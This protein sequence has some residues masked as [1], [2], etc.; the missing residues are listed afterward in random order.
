MREHDVGDSMYNLKFINKHW[1][2]IA[3]IML[4]ILITL[5]FSNCFFKKGVRLEFEV[6]SEM[7]VDY[8]VFY[9]TDGEEFSEKKS[10]HIKGKGGDGYERIETVIISDDVEL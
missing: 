7:P 10:V 9:A 5:M 4:S 2:Y 3:I 8:Q 6:Q 1:E